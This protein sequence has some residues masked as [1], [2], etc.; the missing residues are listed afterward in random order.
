M[1]DLLLT[2]GSN[3]GRVHPVYAAPQNRR[4]ASWRNRTQV[5]CVGDGAG[6]PVELGD[7]EGVAGPAGR[8]G[9]AQPL[10]VGGRCR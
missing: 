8:E 3:M 6:E 7:D 2:V 5:A 1:A 4:T 10:G 9:L